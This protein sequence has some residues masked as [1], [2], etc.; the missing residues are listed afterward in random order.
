MGKLPIMPSLDSAQ[1]DI[2]F[3]SAQDDIPFNS[4]FK[5]IQDDMMKFYSTSLNPHRIHG[6]G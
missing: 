4:S 6:K 1:D 3:D 5:S 2:P